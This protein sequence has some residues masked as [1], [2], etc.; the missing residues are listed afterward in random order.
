MI[1]FATNEY[2]A[3]LDARAEK[4]KQEIL[5]CESNYPRN[6][7]AKVYV[8]KTHGNDE[9][10]GATPETAIYSL[11]R[12]NELDVPCGTTVLFERG[13]IWRGQLITKPACI[14][15]AY[16]EGRKPRFYGVGGSGAGAE[17][18]KETECPN[19]W[20]FSRIIEQDVG[21][22]VYNDGEKFGFRRY[23]SSENTRADGIGT[24]EGF[25]DFTEDLQF[26][27]RKEDNKLFVYSTQGNPGERFESIEIGAFT[28]VVMIGSHGIILDNLCVRYGGSHLF[29][30][31]NAHN[32]TIRNCEIG[33]GGGCFL[34]TT[35]RYGNGVEMYH[36]TDGLYVYNNYIYQIYD[37]ALT[38][39]SWHPEMDTLMQNIYFEDNLVEY[40]YWSI[41]YLCVG[42][43][44]ASNRMNHVRFKNNFLRF[45][46][47][48]FGDV[49][50]NSDHGS[51]IHGRALSNPAD[52]FEI[53]GNILDRAKHDLMFVGA[54]KKEYLPK[55]KNNTYIQTEGK[56]MIKFGVN[57]PE[58]KTTPLYY[59]NEEDAK[60]YI[61]ESG[62]E[63]P[64]I[65]LLK[66]EQFECTHYN[67]R[68]FC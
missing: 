26:W 62:E 13:D 33:W 7:G 14:Y 68:K 25:A 44:S 45:A 46:G 47:Y 17:N 2:L 30:W 34:G 21:N 48:G 29:S 31:A 58:T 15:S 63:N 36:N 53:E 23:L 64:E 24:F 22:I 5:N 35:T 59:A 4:R 43:Y 18:W 38:Y 16:G 37:A 50:F 57:D 51:H 20:E 39:Q 52:D 19:V 54:D 40:C 12:L 65:V 6:S 55:M 3:S 41:E 66:K 61:A 10:D 49:R 67:I 27:H 11:K 42:D 28:T 56:R 60:K 1:S 32:V 9:N 8:S